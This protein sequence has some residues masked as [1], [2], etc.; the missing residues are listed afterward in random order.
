MTTVDRGVAPS[1][2]D[3]PTRLPAQGVVYALAVIFFVISMALS[4]AVALALVYLVITRPSLDGESGA[5]S[6]GIA[7]RVTLW[8]VVSWIPTTLLLTVLWRMG[9]KRRT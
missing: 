4:L 2:P 7:E 3:R 1:R 6:L 5:A 9:Q 8:A